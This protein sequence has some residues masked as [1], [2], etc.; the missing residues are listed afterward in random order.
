MIEKKKG[1]I[2]NSIDYKENHK[3]I[4]VLTADGK[5][6]FLVP[7]AK[8]IK[9]GLSNDTQNLTYCEFEVDSKN[10]LPKAK[11]I[12][13]IDYYNEI[14]ND[15]KKYSVAS[16]AIELIYRMVEDNSASELLF[17]MLLEFFNKLKER[18]DEKVLLLQFRIK[19][20][21]FLGVQPNFKSCVHCNSTTDLVGLS[22]SY[23][24][25]ECVK[26]TSSD[27]IGIDATKII[28]LLYLDKTFS[29]EIEDDNIFSYI[30]NLIDEY[31]EK[32]QYYGLKSKKMLENLKCY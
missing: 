18:N 29:L 28:Q 11:N 30:S 4:Y 31:Y 27:N 16:Y 15:L 21:Y 10:S 8:R 25:M 6:S 17:K 14:K 26:H 5:E 3:I 12:D 2:L 24:S 1:I 19:M 9:S 32:H 23:G 20:L 22:I 7:L 13:V